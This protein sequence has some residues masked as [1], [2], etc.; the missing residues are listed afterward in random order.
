MYRSDVIVPRQAYWVKVNH[1]GKLILAESTYV[2]YGNHITIDRALTDL[3]P[4]PPGDD[5]TLAEEIP[6][7]FNLEQNYPNPFNLSTTLSFV[8][9]HSSFVML[10]LYNVLGQEVAK[11]VNHEVKPGDYEV[12]WNASGLLSGVCFYELVS[13]TDRVTKRMVI[14]K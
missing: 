14:Q 3:P 7:E 4:S 11:L 9:S 8:I 2:V 10:K 5:N 12:S 13:G 1:S 6:R